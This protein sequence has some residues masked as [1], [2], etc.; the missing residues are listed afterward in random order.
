MRCRARTAALTACLHAWPHYWEAR[1]ACSKM[2]PPGSSSMT[3][4]VVA[5]VSKWLISA[6]TCGWRHLVGRQ[7]SGVGCQ[8]FGLRG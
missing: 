5:G 7:A 8:V 2:S 4:Y 3:R 1:R 6:T